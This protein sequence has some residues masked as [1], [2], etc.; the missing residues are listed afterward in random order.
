MSF[1]GC[2]NS[3]SAPPPPSKNTKTDKSAS[4]DDGDTAL[5]DKSLAKGDFAGWC[6]EAALSKVTQSKPLAEY[7]AQF[8]E[9]GE[10]TTLFSSSLLKTAFS[11][12]G[13]PKLSYIDEISSDTATK[14]TTAYF[15][16]AIKIPTTIQT[17]Y[18]EVA[19][20]QGNEATIREMTA[21]QKATQKTLTITKRTITDK[22]WKRGWSIRSETSMSSSGVNITTDSTQAQDQY[23]LKADSLYLF[24]N[25]TT[26]A[27]KTIKSLSMVTAGLDIDNSGYLV[28]V[29]HLVVDN[30][31]LASVAETT[32]QDTAK[33]MII[34]MYKL[35]EKGESSTAG[36]P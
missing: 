31:G 19:P 10:P 11:G 23:E 12:S 17:Y 7:F 5:D 22:Y 24:T 26:T 9:G 2:G 32:I 13:A 20:L 28:T 34:A 6:K 27:T 8:C 1:L 29:V 33:S 36:T 30:L 25:Q 15:G 18:S 21:A 3:Q 16:V 4:G 14:T 35:S